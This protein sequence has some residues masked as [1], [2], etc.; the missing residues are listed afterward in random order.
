MR[1]RLLYRS[2]AGYELATRV[3]YG[4]HYDDRMRAVANEVPHG[5]SVLELCCGPGALYTRCLEPR[6]WSYIGLDRNPAFVKRL[7]RRGVDAHVADLARS[8]TRLPEAEVVIIQASL[9]HFLPRPEPLLDRML[10]AASDRVIVSEPLHNR[11]HQ[12]FTETTLD[13]LFERYRARVIKAALIPGGRE[14]L[15]V[16]GAGD[17]GR[18]AR[19]A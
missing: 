8:D 11:N 1:P 19:T 3:L 9:Y 12:R 16:L 10:A 4:R 7:N 18:G 17:P 13:T 5:A 6:V 14:K 15:Y 2:A